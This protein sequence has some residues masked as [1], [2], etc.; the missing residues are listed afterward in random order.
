M[1]MGLTASTASTGNDALVMMQHTMYDVVL[2]DLQMPVMD[3][4]ECT[5]RLRVWEKKNREGQP[6]QVVIGMSANAEQS[7]I[8]I[9]R[10]HGMDGFCPKPVKLDT[11]REVVNDFAICKKQRLPVLSL[12]G[13][14]SAQEEDTAPGKNVS[15]QD[16][17]G[18]Q[19]EQMNNA[20]VQRHDQSGQKR[21]EHLLLETEEGVVGE[22][23]G[24]EGSIGGSAKGHPPSADQSN[25][26]NCS[27]VEPEYVDRP[28]VFRVYGH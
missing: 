28:L 6:R 12:E 9:C 4:P 16:G 21:D 17:E 26:S 10:A 20:N 13:E 25:V 5:R 2:C 1:K 22:A 14:Q 8:E 19:H 7:D 18:A 23:G 3:G 27:N 24:N 15:I 11:L